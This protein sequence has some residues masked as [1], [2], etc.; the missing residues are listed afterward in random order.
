[1]EG[2]LWLLA[3]S[4]LT[5]A[6]IKVVDLIEDDKLRLFKHD[7]FVFAVIYGLLI[8]YVI[9][10]YEVVAPLWIGAIFAM[11]LAKK[12]DT[13]AHILGVLCALG[14]VAFYGLGKVNTGLL[15]VFTI[16]AFFDEILS[17]LAEGRPLLKNP[18]LKKL[19]RASISSGI[20]RVL[21]LR[22]LLDVAAF[23]VSVAIG[24]FS[25]FMAIV[26]FDT[27]YNLTKKVGL[28]I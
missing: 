28:R 13:K 22:L 24:D 8:G 26:A 27:G 25:P 21:G 9:S 18:M 10:S 14:F 1:M 5:G 23:V 11:V 15:V 3:I 19:S 12:I 4:F 2:M 6:S 7:R 17:D 16:A 20:K